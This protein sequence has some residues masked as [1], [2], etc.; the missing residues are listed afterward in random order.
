MNPEDPE[1]VPQWHEPRFPGDLYTPKWVRG[2]GGKREG[3]CGICKPGRWLVMKNSM[4]WYDKS[5]THGVCA[6]IGAAFQGPL[7]TRA[8]GDEWE[9]L[10]GS[11]GAWVPLLNRKKGRTTW[12]RHVYKVR[13]LQHLDESSDM[14]PSATA[15]LGPDRRQA[16][17]RPSRRRPA[18][19]QKVKMRYPSKA[20]CSLTRTGRCW[21]C[22]MPAASAASQRTPIPQALRTVNCKL[23]PCTST[24]FGATALDM[25]P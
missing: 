3:W 9:G 22:R 12:F 24:T 7:D 2:H 1:L 25:R 18:P 16:L 23:S 17:F 20:R 11:C 19:A 5:F 8:V 14:L 21:R 6:P 10:C 4:Y 15:I 13:T